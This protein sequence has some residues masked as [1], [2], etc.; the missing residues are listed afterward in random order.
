MCSKCDINSYSIRGDRQ[1][2]LI[3]QL[4]GRRP[5]FDAR[6]GHLPPPPPYDCSKYECFEAVIRLLLYQLLINATNCMKYIF[7][8]KSVGLLR[9]Y[10]CN[11]TQT[12][13]FKTRE[14]LSPRHDCNLSGKQCGH[15]FSGQWRPWLCHQR[16][17]SSKTWPEPW[18]SSWID[19]IDHNMSTVCCFSIILF[20]G[21][22]HPIGKSLRPTWGCGHAKPDS[23]WVLQARYQ[24]PLTVPSL[25]GT[26][27]WG[28]PA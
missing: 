24:A 2:G 7:H 16:A 15:C 19:H 14:Q 8:F 13:D 20:L 12:E 28:R 21:V 3:A 18:R 27:R 4:V 26:Y 23:P 10:S 22:F 6:G 1:Y 25:P 17:S 9:M 11:V 5:G